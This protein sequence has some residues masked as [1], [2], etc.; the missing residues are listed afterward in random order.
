VNV[1]LENHI[2]PPLDEALQKE[3]DRIEQA[4]IKQ[5]QSE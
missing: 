2:V 1:I 4:A 3:L 5:I